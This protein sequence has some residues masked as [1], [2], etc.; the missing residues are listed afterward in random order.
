MKVLAILALTV[1]LFADGF[2]S[3]DASAWST[4]YDWTLSGTLVYKLEIPNSGGA[5]ALTIGR[6]RPE[7]GGID[8]LL[9]I[10]DHEQEITQICAQLDLFAK[11]S[12]AGWVLS[13]EPM[14]GQ[15]LSVQQLRH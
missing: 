14:T 15:R 11:I 5:W 7:A 3:G 8:Y 6:E 12:M 4:H 1:L 2:E 13:N 9:V 10:C